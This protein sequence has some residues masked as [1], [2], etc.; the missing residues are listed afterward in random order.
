MITLANAIRRAQ[1][2]LKDPRRPISSFVFI[3]PTGV[4]KTH[5]A[6]ALAEYMFDDPD[7]LLRPRHVGVPGTPHGLEVDRRASRL[8]Q[9]TTRRAN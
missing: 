3:G 6:Q 2:G 5:L 9:G 7:A 1:S 4:G 8:R